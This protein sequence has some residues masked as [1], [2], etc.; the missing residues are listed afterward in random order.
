MCKLSLE[1][2]LLNKVEISLLVVCLMF[3]FVDYMGIYDS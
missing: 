1:F 3:L 2:M